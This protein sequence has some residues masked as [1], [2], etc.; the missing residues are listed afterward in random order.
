VRV[1]IVT[2][3]LPPQV[4]GIQ[5]YVD[6]LARGLAAAGDDVT[7]YGSTPRA[8]TA[9]EDW[10]THDDAAPFDVVRE[11]TSVLLP[12][13][14]VQRHVAELVRRIDAEVVVFG[15]TVPLAFMGGAIRRRTGVPNVCWTHGLE[16]SAVR[17]PGSAPVLRRIGRNAGAIT[18][19]SHWCRDLLSPAFGPDVRSELLPPGIDPSE[20]HPGV[21]GDA[22]RRRHGLGDRPVV[23]C[24][25]R[26][27]E[28]KGQDQLIRALPELRRRVPGTALLIVG[29]GPHRES[30]ER[31]ATELDVADDVVFTGIVD[32]AE[33]PA[34]YAAGDVFAMPC[35]ERRGGFEVEAFGIVFIQALAV[36]VPVVA[37]N[38]GGVP[39][40]VGPPEPGSV[41]PE[42]GSVP[43]SGGD[44]HH[45]AGQ[46]GGLSG[47]LLVDGTDLAEVTD[48]VAMLLEDRELARRLGEQGARRVAEGFTWGARTEQLRALLADVIAQP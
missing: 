4:G 14:R 9:E 8:G 46:S 44:H 35:R 32:G 36:G 19:V 45:S 33:L 25:S 7:L 34:H 17:M 47:G 21:S 6:Q 22:V 26:L 18:Y 31:L 43:R 40:A 16:V 27:V 39:D 30:L 24:V 41:P 42:P 37:G 38:I 5:H 13:P 10:R 12:T 11:R 29:G 28:R 20:F 15:A 1:L 48:A 2:N 3:D 23:V